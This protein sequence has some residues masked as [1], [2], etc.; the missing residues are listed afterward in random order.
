MSVSGGG[1][2]SWG[3]LVPPG[4]SSNFHN[5]SKYYFNTKLGLVLFCIGFAILAPCSPDRPVWARSNFTTQKLS[6]P[7]SQSG[8]SGPQ[9]SGITKSIQNNTDC[10]T[11]KIQ[12]RYRI[13]TEP[14][15]S[16]RF[17]GQILWFGI[18]F[19]LVLYFVGFAIGVV[20]YWFCIY[21]SLQT[22]PACLGLGE[23]N[24][25]KATSVRVQGLGNES[26]GRGPIGLQQGHEGEAMPS[27]S[28][29]KRPP[30]LHSPAPSQVNKRIRGNESRRGQIR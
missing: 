27:G 15:D 16:A 14:H 28:G 3:V 20:L 30:S 6:Y 22:R 9:G 1:G 26:P 11:H 12:K 10:K 24:T 21:G 5:R 17:A 29:A 23:H 2:G 19:V 13:H 18:V 8:R 4:R 7:W 25:T